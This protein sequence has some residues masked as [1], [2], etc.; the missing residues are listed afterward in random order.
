MKPTP[1]L[2]LIED[3]PLDVRLLEETCRETPGWA[4]RFDLARSLAEAR[5]RLR[6]Q[7]YDAVLL[8][9]GLPESDGLETLESFLA[10]QR[11]RDCPHHPAV[12]VLTS[13]QAEQVG[14]AAIAMGAQDFLIKGEI[15]ARLLRRSVRYACE[16]QQALEAQR[17]R[18]TRIA[19]MGRALDQA[20]DAVIITDAAGTIRYVN[21]AF[22]HITGYDAAEAIGRSPALLRS[23]K[24]GSAFYRRMWRTIKHGEP[25]HS[26]MIDRR[27]DGSFYPC[28]L[29]I[30]PVTDEEGAITH[31]VGIQRDL[32]EAR[33]LEARLRRNQKMEAIGTLTGGIAHE[34]NNMLAG[35]NGNLFLARHRLNDPGQLARRLEVI[36]SLCDRAA[37]MIRK[38]MAFGRTGMVQM[39]PVVLNPLLH[40]VCGAMRRMLP[41][42]IHLQVDAV[43]EPLTVHGDE[44]QLHEVLVNLLEN[45][46]DALEERDLEGEIR[47]SLHP[48]T[49][50]DAF[51]A[52]HPEAEGN[53]YARLVVEDDGPGV[54]E[55]VLPHVTEPFFTTKE[56]GA[57]SGL[58]LSMVEGSVDQ[59]HG[60]LE[61]DNTPGA[62]LRVEIYLPLLDADAQ[63]QHGAEELPHALDALKAQEQ[64]LLRGK[65]E[66]ILLADDEEAVRTVLSEAL[67]SMGYRVVAAADGDE[68]LQRFAEQRDE[69]R[70]VLLDVVMPKLGGPACYRAMQRRWG[71]G[72]LPVIFASGFERTRVPSELLAGAHQRCLRK[73][74][75]IPYLCRVL[76]QL[77]D[78]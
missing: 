63:Q 20:S 45:A 13:V 15:D 78:R 14:D 1:R 18:E 29:E 66:T 25:W 4:V 11:D 51:L 65:G 40:D 43:D 72:D 44:G 61:I 60:I 71:G 12:I 73:P 62:G 34:F 47:C 7:Q 52:R 10:L 75:G 24:Q 16:R 77:L 54:P 59:H 48:C 17:E 58:G 32:T 74:F 35:I 56:V 57:G 39:E 76:R 5:D 69:I 68:A 9:L 70:L 19:L 28:H 21:R 55:E 27:K 42:R 41:E 2:L 8:D 31:F 37:G 22:T 46:R 49:P 30:T 6:Q 3:N 23:G 50:D 67:E 36:E 64:T 53:R 33:L 38:M 26:E